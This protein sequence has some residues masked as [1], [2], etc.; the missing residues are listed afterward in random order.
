MINVSVTLSPIFTMP[1]SKLVS[2]RSITGKEP[3]IIMLTGILTSTAFGS[4]EFRIRSQSYSPLP[5]SSVL[6]VKEICSV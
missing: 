1:K 4:L 3:E 5:I 2:E 6:T